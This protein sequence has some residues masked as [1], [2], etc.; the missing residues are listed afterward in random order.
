MLLIPF[1]VSGSDRGPLVVVLVLEKDNLDRMHQA[2]PVDVH[3]ADYKGLMPDSQLG[4]PIHQLGLVIAYEEDKAKLL[5]FKDK[6]DV[7]GLMKWLE[8]GRQILTG[9]LTKPIKL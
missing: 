2:D 9:D 4:R 5:E 6:N 7:I 1:E 8:R 3:F